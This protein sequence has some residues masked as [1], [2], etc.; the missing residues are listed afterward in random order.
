MPPAV[1]FHPE[2]EEQ[3]SLHVLAVKVDISKLDQRQHGFTLLHTHTGAGT[4]PAVNSYFYSQ[5]LDFQAIKHSPG[6]LHMHVPDAT[7]SR[8]WLPPG[9]HSRRPCLQSLGK[10]APA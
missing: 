4:Q 1:C 9:R 5:V 7:R 10:E 3:E 2:R 6:Q 8:G